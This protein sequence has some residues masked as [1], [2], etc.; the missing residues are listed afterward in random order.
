MLSGVIQ[1]GLIAMV[2]VGDNKLFV[3]HGRCQQKND[4]GIGDA[5]ELVKN[6][7][8]VCDFDFGGTVVVIENLVDAARRIRIEHEYLA[9]MGMRGFEQIEAVALGFGEGLLMAENDLFRIIVQLAE[10][11]ET[12]TFFDNI[13][14]GNAKTLG[15][16]VDG[17]VLLLDQY[18]LF[19]PRGKV[20]G[21][22]RVDALTALGIE[23]FW[24][25][26]NDAHQVIRAALIVGLLHRRRNLVVGL[27]NHVLRSNDGGIVVPRAKRKDTSHTDGLAPRLMF[28]IAFRNPS[29][30]VWDGYTLC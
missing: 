20:A 21:C 9:K 17:R 7:V 1:R 22:A 15:V 12:A 2:A 3:S 4:A 13:S 19:A 27:S 28:R 10:S 24:Q 26:K 14:T 16:G 25:A 29:S 30:A 6:A 18:T 23:Q 11:N 5:P 8:F